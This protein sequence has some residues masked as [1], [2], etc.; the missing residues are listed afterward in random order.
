MFKTIVKPTIILSLVGFFSAFI[1]SHVK[2]VTYP[3]IVRQT[4]E[5]Q[6]RALSLVLPGY[7]LSEEKIYGEGGNDFH[8]W[9]GE[10]RENGA[11]KRGYAFIASY[12]GFSGEIKSIIGVNE[13]GRILGI[14]ILRQSET[15]GLGARCEEIASKKTF[16]G[17]LLGTEVDENSGQMMPWFQE[18]FRGL[19]AREKMKIM[20]RGDWRKEIETE[21]INQNAITAITGATITSRAVIMS[22]EKGIAVL[23]KAVEKNGPVRGGAQ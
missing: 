17:A 19:S 7:T 3:E 13:S 21:L 2:S 18:Q 22:L 15:P 4:A 12:S 14:S 8:Y 5:K 20:K 1:L 6:N 10:I 16:F 11:A 23:D 9:E